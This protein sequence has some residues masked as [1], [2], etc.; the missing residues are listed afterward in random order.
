MLYL[1]ETPMKDREKVEIKFYLVGRFRYQ[2]QLV[3]RMFRD[4]VN[5]VSSSIVRL[6]VSFDLFQSKFLQIYHFH[7]RHCRVPNQSK[8]TMMNNKEMNKDIF[9]TPCLLLV[10]E[11][12]RM[13]SSTYKMYV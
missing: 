4:P 5:F 6:I 11:V 13:L 12:K 10:E 3:V 1:H 2:I 8:K 9:H 7:V